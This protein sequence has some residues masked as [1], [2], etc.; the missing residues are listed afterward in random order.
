M[1][2]SGLSTVLAI[3]VVFGGIYLVQHPQPIID[4]VTVWQYEPTPVVEGHVE[5]LGL[6]EHG[7]FLYY[8]SK[9]SIES[10]MAFAESCPAHEGEDGFGI[11][12][13]KG[14]PEKYDA[15]QQAQRD[16]QAL[17]S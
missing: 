13:T 2:A 17:R 14:D 1:V 16:K 3:S 6:T 5:R 7:K 12:A 15:D 9:P 8:A 11:Q 10:S 4:Q